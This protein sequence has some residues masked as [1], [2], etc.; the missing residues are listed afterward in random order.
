[1]MVRRMD[2]KNTKQRETSEEKLRCGTENEWL[3]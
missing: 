3:K 1:M 2:E